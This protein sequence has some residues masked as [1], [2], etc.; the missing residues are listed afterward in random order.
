VSVYILLFWPN[1]NTR[2]IRNMV[3]RARCWVPAELSSVASHL[4]LPSTHPSLYPSHRCLVA[5]GRAS[6]LPVAVAAAPAAEPLLANLLRSLCWQACSRPPLHFHAPTA[7][8]Q[9]LLLL[10]LCMAAA[11]GPAVPSSMATVLDT[12]AA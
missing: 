3:S 6:A 9:P 8:V 1:S 2:S 10:L 12:L 4:T 5:Q 11:Q 7:A